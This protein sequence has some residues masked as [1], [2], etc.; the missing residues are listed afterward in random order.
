M[1]GWIANELSLTCLRERRDGDVSVVAGLAP[2][3][4]EPL[5]VRVAALTGCELAWI[6]E[7]LG[8]ARAGSP[9]TLELGEDTEEGAGRLLAFP[10]DDGICVLFAPR[11]D[12]AVLVRRAAAA[13]H[14][15]GV[16]HEVANSLTAIA[17]WTRMASTGAPLPE[18][19]RQALD[20]VQ[21]S[22]REALDTARG[23]LRTMRDSGH[24][25]IAPSLPD[26]TD[27][28]AVIAEVLETLRPE[29][30]TQGVT[31]IANLPEEV[32]GAAPPAA[33][34]LIVSNLVR[35][36]LEAGGRRI[37]V[38]VRIEG[39]RFVVEVGDDGP[40][41]PKETL[42]RAFER[43]F[44]TKDS[45]TGLG[46]AMVRDT[47][48]EAGGRVEVQSQAGQGTQFEIVLPLAGGSRMSLRP[49]RVHEVGA[50]TSGVHVRPALARRVVLVVDDDEAV[51]S[52]VRTALELHG[53]LVRVAA[54]REG[55]LAAAATHTFDVALI[56]LSL[57]SERGDV[58]L[59]ELRDLGKVTWAVLMTGSAEAELS[60]E[61]MPDAVLRKPF[62]LSELHRVVELAGPDEPSDAS[63]SS[64]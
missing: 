15:A 61:G 27:S 12:P 60:P 29:V 37:E 52:L 21:R 35:N 20:V 7:L 48:H 13:D 25:T 1:V 43:Y 31:L 59:A 38:S 24:A 30:E 64:S 22:A 39:D 33:L 50:I 32:W 3:E 49:P 62:E 54:D 36:A 6:E 10:D 23:L 5:A 34:R 19:T 8:R 40:G 18:R 47:V 2:G 17:G 53:A 51:R 42:E 56:D 11:V 28:A 44:T 26:R 45:G 9:A 16:T 41:M 4:G 57:G 58:L 46:L 14:A 55:A 63:A